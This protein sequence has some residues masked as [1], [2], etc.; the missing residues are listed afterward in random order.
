MKAKRVNS[1]F[2]NWTCHAISAEARSRFR[3]KRGGTK[4]VPAK[5]DPL[6]AH[7]P[8]K[9]C[10]N[11][12]APLSQPLRIEQNAKTE[13]RIRAAAYCRVSTLLDS[14]ETSI[15]SQQMHYDSLIRAHE[16]WDLAGI[17][18]EAGVSGT[19]AENRPELQRLLEDCRQGKI[20]LIL[21]KSISRFAR[22]TTDCIQMVRTLTGLG[23]DIL[24]EKENIHT[25]TMGSELLLTLL[26][27][28]AADESRNISENMKW[29]I[30][31]RFSDGT[32]RMGMEPYG[33][34][35]QQG[36]LVILEDEAEI[37]RRIF[38][39]ALTGSGMATI[40]K[41]LNRESIP[42]PTGIEWTQPT[43]RRILSNPVYKGDMLYQ[44][45]YMDE[46]YMQKE[47]QGELDRYYL[48]DHHEGI[49][50]REDFDRTQDAI[51]LRAEETGHRTEKKAAERHCA[52]TSLFFCAECGSVLHRHDRKGSSPTW[53]CYTHTRKPEKCGMKPQP[54]ED[55]RIASLNCLNKLAWSQKQR[56]PEWRILDAYEQILMRRGTEHV[57]TGLEAG[58][59]E[60]EKDKQYLKMVTALLSRET[61]SRQYQNDLAELTR[62]TRQVRLQKN[63]RVSLPDAGG[64]L[65]EMK[66]L[67]NHWKAS[68]NL[69]DFPENQFS[70]I[71]EKCV[72]ST[73]KSITI[74]FRCG[75]AVTESLVRN[76]KEN[77]E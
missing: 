31:K 21:T 26:A 49:V 19:K 9:P 43:I 1:G 54:E 3:E 72:I 30:R 38:S 10:Q 77:A 50:S 47:N 75:L 40:A 37:V 27:C 41:M 71:V 73:G 57:K 39:L 65:P 69:G 51:R 29:G 55:L 23:V 5:D 35:Q 22:N 17:Y 32:Y 56:K 15:E 46:H 63:A 4:P 12:T 44:K 61:D 68:T 45:T 62:E 6:D 67:V 7:A 14:Q 60:T 42:S 25:G 28:L 18:L 20:D 13:P 16:E 36:Q 74:H 2:Q 58:N 11:E 76:M 48:A 33:Y 66:D 24:F 34:G 59:P 53:I 8:V 64:L 70:R 52:F